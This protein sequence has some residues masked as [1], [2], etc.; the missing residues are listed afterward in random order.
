M[1]KRFYIIFEFDCPPR[2]RIVSPEVFAMN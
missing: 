2:S 1:D